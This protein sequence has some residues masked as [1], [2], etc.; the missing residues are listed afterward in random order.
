[1][2]I[3]WMGLRVD[4]RMSK[5]FEVDNG[6]K[7]GF[8]IAVFFVLYMNKNFKTGSKFSGICSLSVVFCRWAKKRVKPVVIVKKTIPPI[9]YYNP[10]P[11]KSE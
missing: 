11:S 10:L 6:L 7:Q 8:N 9:L 5:L 3:F 2:G 4:G 1:M